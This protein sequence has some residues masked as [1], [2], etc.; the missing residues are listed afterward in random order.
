MVYPRWLCGK[1]P[2]CNAGGASSIPGSGRSPRGGNGNPLQY[3]YLG[4][5]LDREAWW[6]TVH[7]VAKSWTRLRDYNNN[8]KPA[9]NFFLYKSIFYLDKSPL[10]TLC[11]CSRNTCLCVLSRICLLTTPGTVAHQAPLSMRFPRQEYWSR[12]SFPPLGDLPDPGVEPASPALA[13]DSLPL[14]HPGSPV[15][16][17]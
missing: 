5:T 3:S 12:L 9:P 1:E 6:A 17:P 11:F 15:K 13:G 2:T 14:S 10:S 4:N 16:Q 7:G 8:N